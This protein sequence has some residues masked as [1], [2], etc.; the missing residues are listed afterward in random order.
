M[1]E[2]TNNLVR[3][4]SVRPISTT[5]IQQIQSINTLGQALAIK[6]NGRNYSLWRL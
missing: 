6:L 1:A 3:A 5:T 2:S 4:N